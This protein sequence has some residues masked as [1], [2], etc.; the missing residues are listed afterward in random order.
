MSHG[1]EQDILVDARPHIGT[2]KLP[3]I[4]TSIKDTILNA[5]GEVMFDT[6]MTDILVEFGKVKGIELNFED[7]LFADH[8]I[9]ATGHSARDVYE[10]LNRK[11][12]L[13]R[14]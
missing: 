6:Q 1:A 7:K 12:I 5:G 14:S 10:L 8:I 2:N 11:N 13:I 3:H 9:L 4:I